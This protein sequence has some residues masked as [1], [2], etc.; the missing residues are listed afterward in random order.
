[1][2]AFCGNILLPQRLDK[3]IFKQIDPLGP[4]PGTVANSESSSDLP[5]S[6]GSRITSFTF[7]ED[8]RLIEF[9]AG[10]SQGGSGF[11]TNSTSSLMWKL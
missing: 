11:G 10:K 8:T 4:A 5:E 1:M 6:S 2:E 9:L 3:G 7:Q